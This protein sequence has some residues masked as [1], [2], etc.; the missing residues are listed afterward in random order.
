MSYLVG[1]LLVTSLVVLQSSVANYL[2]LFSGRPDLVLLAVVSWA[3]FGKPQEAMVWGFL[4]GLWLGLLSEVPL[5]AHSVVLVLIALLISQIEGRLWEA[6]PIM[7]LGGVL[8]ASLIF[9]SFGVITTLVMGRSI[10][11]DITLTQVILP[12]VFL[13]LILAIPAAQLAEGLNEV[14]HPPE[15]AV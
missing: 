7:Q 13:N 6:N 8:I 2:V 4:G 9:Y 5:G 1:F 15:V 11:W 14:L 10:A 12:S 3:V